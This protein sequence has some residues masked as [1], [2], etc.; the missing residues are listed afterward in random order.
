MAVPSF[1]LVQVPDDETMLVIVVTKLVK[2][3]SV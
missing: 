1:L 2:D 3:P